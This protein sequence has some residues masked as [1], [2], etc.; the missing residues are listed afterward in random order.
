MNAI[1]HKLTLLALFAALPVAA[2]TERP[3]VVFNVQI[4]QVGETARTGLDGA[5]ERQAADFHRDD[6]R[7]IHVLSDATDAPSLVSA[8]RG[9]GREV[10]S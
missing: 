1:H 6:Q 7:S 4:V 10:V 8:Q 9:A 3:E 2:Q 5:R